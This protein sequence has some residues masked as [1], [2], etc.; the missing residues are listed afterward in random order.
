MALTRFEKDMVII[1]QLDDQPN[2]VGGLTA[3]ELKAKF[4]E[5]GM[6]VK[7]YLNDTLLPELDNNQ[8][9]FQKPE[10]S[11]GIGATDK[12]GGASTVQDELDKV[13]N[14]GG[15]TSTA[16]Q[17][18]NAVRQMHSH[19]NKALLDGY[20]QTETALAS[21][22]AQKH[23]H[24]NKALLDTYT[25]SNSDLA[26]SVQQRHTHNN[27]AVLDLILGLSQSVGSSPNRVPSEAAVGRLF[28]MIGG[29]GPGGNLPPGGLPGDQLVKASDKNFDATW[30]SVQRQIIL[31]YVATAL[32]TDDGYCITTDD[33]VPIDAFRIL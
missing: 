15:A 24:G 29:G 11:A 16:A 13:S 22:V 19:A 3:A 17:L 18:D 25:Q 7:E 5:G 12:N 6:A 27:K 9:N 10:A 4:D 1:Q 32:S 23:S 33:G 21:A 8:A 31:G 26:S 20:T 30:D 2:D 28:A 14:L